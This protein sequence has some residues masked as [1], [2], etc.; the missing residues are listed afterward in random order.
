MKPIHYE[1]KWCIKKPDKI[2][3]GF[4]KLNILKINKLFEIIE[5]LKVQINKYRK[6]KNLYNWTI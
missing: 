2:K 3:T 6:V 1:F 4:E 5:Q